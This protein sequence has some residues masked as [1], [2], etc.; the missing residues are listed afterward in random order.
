MLRG[1]DISVRDAHQAYLHAK[2]SSDGRIQTWISLPPEYWPNSWYKDP[3]TRSGPLYHNPCV[4]LVLALYGHPESGA[5]WESYLTDILTTRGW[6][7][8]SEWPGVFTHANGSIL[9]VYVDDMILCCD[10][11]DK[12]S[13]WKSIEDGVDFKHDPASI[14]R[15][16]GADYRVDDYNPKQPNAARAIVIGMQDYTMNMS[17][18]FQDESGIS[19]K[20][21]TTPFLADAQWGE[22]SET[23]GRFSS[24]CSSHAATSLFASRVGRPDLAVM[25]QRLC[26]AVSR[27]TTVHDS[28]LVR[29]MAYA[30]HHSRMA[31][32]GSLSPDDDV[33]IRSFSDADWS[34]DPETT[35]ST[36]RFWV[37]LFAKG[38]GHSWPLAWGSMKQTSTSSSTAESE[39]VA[40]S[41][42]VRREV[43]PIQILMEAILGR[44]LKI[45]MLIDNSQALLA[46]QRGYSKKLRHLARTQRVGIGLLNELTKDPDMELTVEHC[47]TLSMKADIFTKALIGP[48]FQDAL[49]M[50]GMRADNPT[51][52]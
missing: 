36:T 13:I 44:R 29:L 5:L 49:E 22:N 43:I 25:T 26:S 15:F 7:S 2:I 47:P 38:S 46:I 51:S 19:P 37:E 9:L 11:K 41:H 24:S 8:I 48:K 45:Q 20:R 39:V 34:G 10:P 12:E 31:L 23:A 17:M 33:V 16:L 40:A 14:G 50:I 1:L 28:A 21:V 52:P 35:K 32:H 6:T 30:H 27:W 42:A 3:A 4:L 18:K